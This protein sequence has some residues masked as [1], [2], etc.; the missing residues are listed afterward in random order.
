MIGILQQSKKCPICLSYPCI[1]K[2]SIPNALK[3]NEQL[4]IDIVEQ[5][6]TRTEYEQRIILY[7]VNKELILLQET[8]P[9]CE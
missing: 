6:K 2:N 4:I 5:L 3:S 9:S 8:K 7:E 1:C